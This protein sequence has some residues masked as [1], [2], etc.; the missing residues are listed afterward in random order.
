M[1]KRLHI[2]FCRF[3][4][5]NFPYFSYFLMSFPSTPS[6]YVVTGKTMEITKRTQILKQRFQ[7]KINNLIHI[8]FAFKMKNEPNYFRL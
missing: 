4:V 1:R 3:A 5:G 8:L 7:F 2:D 6:L